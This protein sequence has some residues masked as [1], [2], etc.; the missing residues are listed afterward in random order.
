MRLRGPRAL[1]HVLLLSIGLT[2]AGGQLGY[3]NT[4]AGSGSS[5][6]SGVVDGVGSA[7]CFWS[8]EGMCVSKDSTTVYVPDKVTHRIRAIDVAT[9]TVST[10]VG[11]APGNANPASEGVSV[12]GASPPFLDGVGTVPR[13]Y[14]PADCVVSLDGTKIYVAEEG[15]H[16]IR[17]VELATKTVTTLAGKGWSSVVDGIGTNAQFNEPRKLTMSADGATL[18]ILDYNGPAVRK[19]DLA[20]RAVTTIAGR[21]KPWGELY[22]HDDG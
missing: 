13:F 11:P 6:S 12:S 19:M 14:K 15:N 17:Q 18:Y 3:V 16:R 20:S 8:P 21:Q 4:L 5:C 9:G 1:P 10:F 7:A 22:T 2:P